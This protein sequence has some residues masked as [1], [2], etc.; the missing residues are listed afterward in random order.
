VPGTQNAYIAAQGPKEVTVFDFWRMVY[1]LRLSV[2]V[3]LGNGIEDGKIKF[4]QY[5]PEDNGAIDIGYFRVTFVSQESFFGEVFMRRYILTNTYTNE[6]SEICHLKYTAFPDHGVPDN[7]NGFLK[8]ISLAEEESVRLGE[9]RGV[10]RRPIV[11]HCSAGVGRTGTYIAV[12]VTIAK[13]N[14]A[15][16]AAIHQRPP[17]NLNF[18]VLDTLVLLRRQRPGMVQT[19]EQLIYC[20]LAILEKVIT[21]CNIL[22]FQNER[23]FN[24]IS[25]HE[26]INVLTAARD[27]SFLFR[28]SSAPGFLSMSY[29]KDQVIHHVRIQVTS[30]GFICEGDEIVY[31]SLQA[32]VDNKRAVLQHPIYAY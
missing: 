11:V 29:N 1:E 10:G 18:N 22:D 20:Y 17:I 26:A 4:W 31:T 25:A 23:W 28:P 30:D 9:K 12:A 21:H 16:T 2:V 32:L 8:L 24:K 13:L 7:T 27:G 15:S 14:Y 5:W 19:K 3:M 6:Q